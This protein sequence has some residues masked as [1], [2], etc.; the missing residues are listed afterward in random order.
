MSY[1]WN[2][3]KYKSASNLQ[4]N[5]GQELLNYIQISE[6]DCIL[7][8]GCG[9]GNFTMEIASIAQKGYVV[10]IDSSASMINKCIETMGEVDIRNVEF[11]NMSLTDII[12]ENKFDIIFSNSVL[13]WI[14]DIEK[15]LN[16]FS[17]ALKPSGYMAVQFPLLNLSH[18]L[19]YFTNK[20]IN[21]LNLNEYYKAWDNPWYAPEEEDF[22]LLLVSQGFNNINICKKQSFFKFNSVKEAYEFFDSIGL[23]LFLSNLNQEKRDLFIEEFIKSLQ[24]VSTE[25]YIEL[26]FERI[27][28][29]ATK[30]K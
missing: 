4:A 8:A 22:K 30:N 9:I 17:R 2:A 12:Y 23:Q 5:I 19:I 18:P 28:A 16:A 3:S 27:F 14:K 13:H 29:F 25:D 20:V 10:G 11:I 24:E 1:I 7:D 21:N 6:D 15:A 26:K